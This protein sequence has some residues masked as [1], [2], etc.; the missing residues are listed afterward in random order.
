M[1]EKE[2][3]Y[4]FDEL[5][6][7]LQHLSFRFGGKNYDFDNI[8]LSVQNGREFLTDIVRYGLY[9]RILLI[10]EKYG[11][12]P[13]KSG[14]KHRDIFPDDPLEELK[15]KLQQKIDINPGLSRKNAI[16]TNTVLK[17]SK[18]RRQPKKKSKSKRR[19]RH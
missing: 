5:H 11:D 13:D 14:S 4:L 3:L 16:L 19:H 10:L 2:T 18:T 17:E 7:V 6:N 15:N 1:D 8:F 9:G 12:I